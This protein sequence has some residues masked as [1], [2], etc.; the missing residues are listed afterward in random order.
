MTGALGGLGGDKGPL[1]GVDVLEGQ[2]VV[3]VGVVGG[4]LL[5]AGR[6]ALHHLDLQLRGLPVP[7]T[8]PLPFASPPVPKPRPPCPRWPT[9]P[10]PSLPPGPFPTPGPCLLCGLS[11]LPPC[12]CHVSFPLSPVLLPFPCVYPPPLALV[13]VSFP[14]PVPVSLA[15]SCIP[16]STAC[17]LAF[18]VCLPSPA[19][20]CACT[21]PVSLSPSAAASARALPL[22]PPPAACPFAHP[23]CLP[24]SSAA[25]HLPTIALCPSPCAFVACTPPRVIAVPSCLDHTSLQ[26]Q[27]R[28]VHRRA[29]GRRGADRPWPPLGEGASMGTAWEGSHRSGLAWCGHSTW[30]P[31]CPPLRPRRF[32]A[33]RPWPA[34]G[35]SPAPSAFPRAAAWQAGAAVAASRGLSCGVSGAPPGGGAAGATAGACGGGLCG[36]HRWGGRWFRVAGGRPGL[37]SGGRTGTT[38]SAGRRSSRSAGVASAHPGETG[39]QEL[40]RRW[41]QS[42]CWGEPLESDFA[43]ILTGVRGCRR[44][45]PT[46]S[47]CIVGVSWAVLSG[48][49]GGGGRGGGPGESLADGHPP[50]LGREAAKPLGPRAAPQLPIFG[51]A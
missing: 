34:Q 4:H 39:E 49:G 29:L 20:A 38:A 8:R 40:D 15:V 37:L 18:P 26:L 41:W 50:V 2:G 9:S 11:R 32:P 14:S 36:R 1:I 46:T 47:R 45:C 48:A 13:A 25:Y 16:A 5:D 42:S 22:Y 28:D 44:A 6:D 17:A 33:R 3:V 7:L 51:R 23:R 12:P 35:Q 19:A 27:Q 43:A 10:P 31:P 21:L 30:H 24:S